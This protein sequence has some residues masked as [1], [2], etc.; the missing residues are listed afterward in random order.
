MHHSHDAPAGQHEPGDSP[1]DQ[2]VAASATTEAVIKG[3]QSSST[4]SSSAAATASAKRVDIQVM[5]ALAVTLVVLYHLGVPGFRGGFIGVDVFFVVSGYLVFGSLLREMSAGSLDV[6]GFLTRRM[7]R[8]SLPSA[9]TL[10]A[11]CA[12]LLCMPSL[13][14]SA[15]RCS[16]SEQFRDL[17]AAALHVAN[18][19]FLSSSR[20]YF[21]DVG[22]PSLVLHFWSLAVEEQLYVAVPLLLLPL[23]A[24]R[25]WV[26]TSSARLAGTFTPLVFSYLVATSAGSLALIFFQ[27]Q[28]VKFFFPASRYWEFCL[29]AAVSHYDDAVRGKQQQHSGQLVPAQIYAVCVAVLFVTAALVTGANWPSAVAVLVAG[30]SAVLI[31]LRL[32]FP[33]SLATSAL[34]GLGNMSYSVYLVHWPVIHLLRLCLPSIGTLALATGTLSLTAGLAYLSYRLIEQRVQSARW[35][36]HLTVA[37]FIAATVVPALMAQ[38]GYQDATFDL[39]RQQLNAALEAEKL[40]HKNDVAAIRPCEGPSGPSRPKLVDPATMPWRL[41]GNNFTAQELLKNAQRVSVAHIT[42]NPNYNHPWHLVRRSPAVLVML[43]GDSH[44]CQYSA[45]V[46]EMAEGLNASFVEATLSNPGARQY[47]DFTTKI[48]IPRWVEDFP[49]RF[50]I[51]AG[52][53]LPK[54]IDTKLVEPTLRYWSSKS[55]CMAHLADGPKFDDRSC[56]LN[57][58]ANV[59]KCTVTEL[60]AGVGLDV[61]I[62]NATAARDASFANKT[63]I[64]VNKDFVC[65]D[66]LC[67][68]HIGNIPVLADRDHYSDMAAAVLH[69]SWVMRFQE[70]RCHATAAQKL[71]EAAKAA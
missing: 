40:A 71:R 64:I 37:I 1:A 28:Q 47:I 19:Q 56:L 29:G 2:E 10:T 50:V 62:F 14:S 48:A 59:D 54:E 16:K 7:K 67:P 39:E 41:D 3:P 49:F 66:G 65:W 53:Y 11:V 27:S 22:G 9:V 36:R 13:C 57:N 61:A 18:L 24:A 68:M 38:V 63:E 25:R 12:T 70:T 21:A 46:R 5:R 17:R 20:A 44:A 32:R 42:G 69:R 8:L 58:I 23:L 15:S 43:V 52:Y 31:W 26:C 60:A 34:E 6:M 55:T 4:S 45:A 35:P 33:A 51:T 30:T